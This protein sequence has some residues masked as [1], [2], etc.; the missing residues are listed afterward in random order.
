MASSF[1][2]IL[3]KGFAQTFEI[4]EMLVEEQSEFQNIKI[5]DTPLN[6]RVMA[7]D[8]IVQITTRDEASYS[9]MLTHLPAFDLMA[10]GA[11][12][13]RVMIVGGGDVAVAEEALKHKTLASVDMAEIDGRVI[14]LC[15]E[16]F[17]ELNANAFSD[18]R[19]KIHV[20][21]A[22]EFLREPSSQ[23]AFDIVIADR[24]D[25]VG[26]AEILFADEFY[27]IVAAAL[28][29][30][31]VAVFQTGVP[32]YQPDELGA[33]IK[34]LGKA[35]RHVGVYTT[36][37]PS[38]TGGLMALTWASNGST[39]GQSNDAALAR[40]FNGSGIETDHYTPA[41]HNAS[42]NLPAWMERLRR[43]KT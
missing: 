34:Q 7:L 36:V 12:M 30:T 28:S 24:P 9:E 39:L 25:P 11:S 20:Q 43:S 22:F 33:T 17:P 6:G 23:G 16:H 2:E 13:D 32:F 40:L 29:P 21:D 19:L 41:L 42:F 26:P 27:E 15:R 8:D 3:H 5:F 4:T 31:G 10:Q 1:T 38:Y 35:F 14:E 18:E 37:T